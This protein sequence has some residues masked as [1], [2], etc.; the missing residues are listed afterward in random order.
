MTPPG[1]TQFN[2]YTTTSYTLSL[3]YFLC[4]FYAYTKYPVLFV[5]VYA[6]SL[7]SSMA[8]KTLAPYSQLFLAV[9][10]EPTTAVQRSTEQKTYQATRLS[11]S[12]R[13][14]NYLNST[15]QSD[16]EV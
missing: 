7:F 5:S 4:I 14:F 12:T 11:F 1:V 2:A 6:N 16:G 10:P 13:V 3:F 8:T 9:S 15:N